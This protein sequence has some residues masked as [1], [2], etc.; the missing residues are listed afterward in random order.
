M[1]HRAEANAEQRAHTLSFPAIDRSVRRCAEMH[2]LTHAS[3]ALQV[4]THARSHARL[5]MCSPRHAHTLT[6]AHGATLATFLSG[7][8]RGLSTSHHK[9]TARMIT[10]ALLYPPHTH[11]Y[12][13]TH[14]CVYAHIH[15]HMDIHTCTHVHISAHVPIE[16]PLYGPLP[17]ET[18]TPIGA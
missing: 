7:T 17:I 5:G 13:R 2:T 3:I 14:I 10:S 1:L 15:T 18:P 4:S 12:T 6:S 8:S 9:R 16:T 11:I